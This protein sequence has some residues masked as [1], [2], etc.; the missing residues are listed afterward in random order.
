MDFLGFVFVFVEQVPDLDASVMVVLGGTQSRKTRL[1]SQMGGERSTR[2]TRDR[3]VLSLVLR[4]LEI[5]RV[6]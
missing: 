3:L 4:I 1:T 2:S 5:S 6:A